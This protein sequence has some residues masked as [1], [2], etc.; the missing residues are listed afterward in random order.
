MP[1]K[2]TYLVVIRE[3]GPAWDSSRPME[4]QELWPEHALF[5]EELASS[6]FVVLGGPFGD[7]QRTMLVVDAESPEA[8]HSRLADDPWTDDWLSTSSIE[9]WRIRLDG[10]DAEPVR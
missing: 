9:P 1:S 6:G 8:V 4:A 5:M 3:R 7:G 2:P 10:R